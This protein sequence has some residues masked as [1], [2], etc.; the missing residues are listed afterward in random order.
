MYAVEPDYADRV[1]AKADAPVLVV[2]VIRPYVGISRT[3]SKKEIPLS[4]LHR[5]LRQLLAANKW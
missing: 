2:P 3:D 4:V 5:R 1:S